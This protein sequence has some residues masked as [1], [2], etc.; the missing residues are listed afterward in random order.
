MT[1]IDYEHLYAFTKE[2]LDLDKTIRWAGITNKFGILLNFEQKQGI[3]MLL[4]EEENEEYAVNTISRQKTR[5]KFQPK[6]GNLLYAFG[7]YQK[8]NRATIPINESYYLLL[9]L[10]VEQKDFNTIIMEKVIPLI[11]KHKSKFDKYAEED[12]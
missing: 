10:D 4:T 9:T 7:R 5:I 3:Q 12:S 11:E 6:I 1:T 2:V 8:V